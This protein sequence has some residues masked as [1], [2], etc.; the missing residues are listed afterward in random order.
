MKKSVVIIAGGQGTRIKEKF[1]DIPKSLI[2]IQNKTLLNYQ[3]DYLKKFD[4]IDLHLCL[5]Y[6]SEQILSEMKDL[7]IDFSYSVEEKPLGTY[8]AL[9]N[10]KKYLNENYF[11]LF[12][13][14]LQILI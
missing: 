5:G 8:G 7:N 4:D 11:V 1:S 12:E 10:S 3:I 9:Y 2:P 13:M 14:L 6:K